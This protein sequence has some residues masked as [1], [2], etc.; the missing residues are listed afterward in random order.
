[1]VARSLYPT[2]TFFFVVRGDQ[3]IRAEKAVIALNIIGSLKLFN[4]RANPQIEPIRFLT[5]NQ[6]LVQH[7]RF[8]F[9]IE[10]ARGS[11]QILNRLIAVQP[12]VL[13]RRIRP[14]RGVEVDRVSDVELE[15]RAA[16]HDAKCVRSARDQPGVAPVLC[17]RVV[18]SRSTLLELGW[19]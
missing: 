5:N 8:E 17:T 1:M 18:S 9:D 7:T 10:D 4:H 14:I 13:E 12:E 16:R 3:L 2:R 15:T 19:T 6:I 11:Q